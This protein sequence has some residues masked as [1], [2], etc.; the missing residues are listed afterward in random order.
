MYE[1]VDRDIRRPISEVVPAQQKMFELYGWDFIA[2]VRRGSD[3]DPFID[4]FCARGSITFGT[5]YHSSG[6]RLPGLQGL[7]VRHEDNFS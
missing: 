4:L 6:E 3:D 1:R 5:A 2:N 7:Y